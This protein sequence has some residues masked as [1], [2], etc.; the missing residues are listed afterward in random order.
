VPALPLNGDLAAVES[1]GFKD[2]F[3]AEGRFLVVL[4]LGSVAFSRALLFLLFSRRFIRSHRN[5]TGF[6]SRHNPHP[7][8]G[9]KWVALS[10]QQT[11]DACEPEVRRKMSLPDMPDPAGRCQTF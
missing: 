7:Q 6:R 5:S 9:E 4:L 10:V 3:G 8:Q 1:H 2:S 11:R